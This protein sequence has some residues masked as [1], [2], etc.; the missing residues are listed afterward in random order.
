MRP[1]ERQGS[2]G[3]DLFRMKLV[4]LLDLRHPLCKLAEKIR[5]QDLIEE[6]GALYSDRGRPGIPIRT[7]VGLHYLKH[8]FDPS[9]ED[10]VQ[11]WVENP[12][13]QY[14]CGEE[15][16]QHQLPIDP[17][18]MTRFRTRLGEAGCEKL[19]QITIN[20]GLETQAITPRSLEAVTVDTTVQEKAVAFPTDARLYHKGRVWLVRLAKASG[21]ELRQT[22]TRIGKN[23]FFMQN[24]YARARQLNRAK[25]ELKRLKTILGRVYRDLQRQMPQ[26]SERVQA[27]FLE[28]LARIEQLLRQQRND[29]N[30]IYSL[31][32]PEVEC[33]AKGKA[34]KKYE[35]GV[36]VSLAATHRDNFVVG[37][38][39]LPGNPY[40]GRTLA[41]ALDQ[42]KRLTGTM[43]QRCFVD[44]GYRKHGIDNVDVYIPGQ[45][46]GIT[47]ALR[48]SIKRRNAIEPIIGHLKNDGRMGRNY[49]KGV[50]GDAMNPILAAAG[51][52][53]RIILRKLRLFVLFFLSA[54]ASRLQMPGSMQPL[55]N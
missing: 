22:Y 55:V 52:N 39:S 40:D 44:R 21:I 2:R 32:A 19:L 3:E 34:H 8:T 47:P 28:P 42:V 29:S 53:L 7:M 51:H 6:F 24:R 1:K 54:L 33:I 36:K 37:A 13:W 31:H 16:F 4:N 49:L 18:Q 48:K 10:T 5:W 17:S 38:Q 43:P 12:Y 35:F 26:Q 30:K 46:R 15:Y 14:F 23:A 25:R 50:I 9:D 41:A 45:K 11:G 20:A 27:R